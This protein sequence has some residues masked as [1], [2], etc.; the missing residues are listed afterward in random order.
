MAHAAVDAVY[1][2]AERLAGLSPYDVTWTVHD[3]RRGSVLAGRA[4]VG[5]RAAPRRRFRGAAVV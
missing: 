3:E 2:T 4:A 5:R 1:E